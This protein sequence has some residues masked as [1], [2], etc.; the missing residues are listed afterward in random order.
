MPRAGVYFAPCTVL[1]KYLIFTK[2]FGSSTSTSTLHFRQSSTQVLIKLYLSTST[3][4]GT[5]PQPCILL[6]YTKSIFTTNSVDSK[7]TYLG[8]HLC[9]TFR[10]DHALV[11]CDLTQIPAE[12]SGCRS[13]AVGVPDHDSWWGAM[14]WCEWPLWRC[15][16]QATGNHQCVIEQI[17]TSHMFKKASAK[18]SEF[19]IN[20]DSWSY[21]QYIS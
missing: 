12:W 9:A 20:F 21:E 3:S 7:F 8:A 13:V 17:E 19:S 5:W 2:Y 15:L 6:T 11:V 4:T 10:S 18:A 14:V 1:E 16:D